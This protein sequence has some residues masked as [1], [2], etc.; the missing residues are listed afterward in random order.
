MLRQCQCQCQMLPPGPP[1]LSPQN[2]HTRKRAA[3]E[4]L[5][6]AVHCSQVVELGGLHGFTPAGARWLHGEW[7]SCVCVSTR[8]P[9]AQQTF[10]THSHGQAS[11]VR[12]GRAA[13]ACR[14]VMP[15]APAMQC[16][17]HTQACAPLL[18]QSGLAA[19]LIAATAAAWVVKIQVRVGSIHLSRKGQACRQQGL[20]LH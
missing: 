11:T 20:R 9:A 13:A 10:S 16:F 5:H 14:C 17:L 2:T 7:C 1:P 6:A 19:D 18:H 3:L 12:A 15:H 4:V 8:L